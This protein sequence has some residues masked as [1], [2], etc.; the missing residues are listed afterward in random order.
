MG[1]CQ[2]EIF[3]QSLGHG[4]NHGPRKNKKG[5]ESPPPVLCKSPFLFHSPRRLWKS[6]VEK[7][8]EN[9]ENSELSTDIF[10]LCPIHA[11]L[12]KTPAPESR[13]PVFLPEAGRYVP[14]G[15]R[16]LFAEMGLKSWFPVKDF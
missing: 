4:K 6:P 16:F 11:P 7:G 1:A 3:A 2:G 10:P 12:W 15:S 9:V 8:V 5:V 13:T 14:A